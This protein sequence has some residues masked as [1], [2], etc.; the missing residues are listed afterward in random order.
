MLAIALLLM[1]PVGL[2]AAAPGWPAQTH[3]TRPWAYWWWMASAV[4]E[5]NITRELQ[6]YQKAGMGGVHIIP[7]YGAKGYES[8]SIEYL[9]PRWMEMLKHTVSEAGRLGLGVDMTTGTGWCFGGPNVSERD[10]CATV[11]V[12]TFD[13]PAGARFAQ[14]FD[15]AATQALVAFSADGKPADFTSRLPENG[16]F[17]LAAGS[18]AWRVY[19]V[20]QRLC[21]T[22]VKRAAP[23]GAGPMLNPFSPDPIRHYLERFTSAFAN[24]NGSMPRAMYHDSFEYGANWSPALFDEFERRRGYR[25]QSA[26]PALLT[27]QEGDRAAR[28]K[29]DYRE[30]L[31]DIMVESF[32]PAWTE[33]CRARGI[34][35]RNQAHGSPGNLLDLYAA[36]DIPETEMFF[37]DRSTVVSKLASSAAHVAGRKLVASE[38]GTWLKEHF[39]ETLADLKDL[40]D[41]I[42]V[43]GVNHIVYHGTAYSP[44]DDP[45]PGWLF[46]AS[47]QMNPRN[48]MWRDVPAL[49]AYIARTQ[50]VLQSGRSDHDVLLYWPIY[51]LWHN[52]K[53]LNLNMSVHRREWIEGQSL[54]PAAEK[55][56]TRGYQFDFVS[57]R[58]LAAAKINA[59][60]IVMPGGSYRAVAV[61]ACERMPLATLERL[62]ALARAG[63]PVVFEGGPP[64]DVPGLHDLDARRTRMKPLLAEL[65]S[66]A[67]TGGLEAALAAAGIERETMADVPG[68]EFVRRAVDGGRAY[69]I[70]NRAANAKAFDG[71]LPLAA[72]SPAALLMDPMTGRTGAAQVRRNRE[73]RT[74]VRVALEAGESIIVRTMA[75]PAGEAWR[76]WQAAGPAKT[77]E[78]EWRISP[79]AGGPELPEAT[80]KAGLGTWTAQGGQWERFGGTARYSILFDAPD[81]K[82]RAWRLDLGAVKESAKVRLNGEDLGTVFI[83][84]YRVAVSGLKTTGNV[85]EVEVT[86]LAA[87]RIRDLDRRKAPWRVFH[88]TNLV[89]I[90]Y[91]PFD[92]SGWP[93]RESGLLGP[94]TLVPLR[95]ATSP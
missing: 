60:S 76:Y 22:P 44:D 63:V 42:F 55:L 6:R 87:N 43:A 37:A 27:E 69:F 82:V 73:G 39:N 79:I 33:W 58:Q 19:W 53:G 52:P 90:N 17:Q 25:L 35:T 5:G 57:D 11:E 88:D 71:W 4:D 94:V 46:Y 24:Y 80:R 28:V 56:L 1:W 8:R 59:R 81:T 32:L 13:V 66:L 95:Q 47:T 86:N 10:A 61:P 75:A 64:K 50:S 89:N 48:P 23:G 41:Q 77:I 68:I 74:E 12:K 45:W 36:A 62:L 26:L 51:D 84:P 3:E 67:L 15:R 72:P 34:R 38:T 20:S 18:S 93:V 85:L 21:R 40:A 2:S 91:K 14:K 83:A 29:S 92:A 7:I 78:G 31:S 70:S 65:Q 9:S 49:N 30:T 54:G 16:A